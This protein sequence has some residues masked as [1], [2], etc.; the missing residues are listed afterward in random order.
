MIGRLI[1]LLAVLLGGF[2][3]AF[4]QEVISGT[5]LI[6]S[7]AT[8]A[9]PAAKNEDTFDILVIGDALAG[10]LGAGL[11]R[12]TE[13]DPSIDVTLR[14]NEQSGLARP[15]VYD[16]TATVP[17]I[18]ESKSFDA[19]VVLV[20]A[21][22][23]QT[24]QS[25]DARYDFGSEEWTKAYRAQLDSILD[26]LGKSGAKVYWV[27]LPPAADQSYDGALQT[28]SKLQKEAVEAKGA[29]FIDI[30]ANFLNPD[31]SYTDT[32]PDDTGTVRRLR[33]RDG[34]SFFKQGNNRLAQLVLEAIKQDGLR[35]A[36]VP[37]QPK[38]PVAAPESPT[39]PRIVVPVFG[40]KAFDGSDMTFTPSDAAA[41]AVANL[42]EG[43]G[44]LQDVGTPGSAAEKL[45]VEGIAAAPPAGRFDDIRVTP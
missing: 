13:Q 15:E 6:G 14:Y 43:N 3:P 23:R 36:A 21:N 39:R 33:G 11:L 24:I 45:F 8:Q 12:M 32:G 10:G 38:G 28:I 42:A 40:Y 5:P 26:I 22:D 37:E 9:A 29:R 2:A 19:T 34:I 18:L 41:G 1:V 44:S 25:G 16:W 30:R 4:G 17:R 27:S 7:T 20:G 31:G 35:L